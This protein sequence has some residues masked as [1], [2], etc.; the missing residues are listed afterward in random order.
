MWYS[1]C[2]KLYSVCV[3][4]R[5]QNVCLACYSFMNTCNYLYMYALIDDSIS[6]YIHKVKSGYLSDDFYFRIPFRIFRSFCDGVPIPFTIRVETVSSS[7]EEV[8]GR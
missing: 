8:E 1:L 2:V 5:L 4:I 6:V 3:K 7:R